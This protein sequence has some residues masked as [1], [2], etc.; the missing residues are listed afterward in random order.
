MTFD[1]NRSDPGAACAQTGG[2]LAEPYSF[3]ASAQGAMVDRAVPG[4]TVGIL[5]SSHDFI[6]IAL[7]W[8]NF[9]IDKS[10]A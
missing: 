10:M 4:R 7:A 6:V 5:D 3:R 1:F 2:G 8:W 9:M